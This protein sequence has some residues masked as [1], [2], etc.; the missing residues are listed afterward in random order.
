MSICR[1]EPKGRAL[2]ESLDTTGVACAVAA[3]PW[4]GRAPGPQ[5][6]ADQRQS[7]GLRMPPVSAAWIAARRLQ[8]ALLMLLALLLLTPSAPAS[9]A[10]PQ[11]QPLVQQLV[12]ACARFTARSGLQFAARESAEA[13]IEAVAARL[14]PRLLTEGGE[15]LAKRT[16]GLV[17]E[18]GP[19]L[20]RVLDD[21][22]LRLPVIE[23]LEKVP[24]AGRSAA[25]SALIREG[26]VLGRALTKVGSEALEAEMRHPGIGAG[27]VEVLGPEGAS[28]AR[29]LPSEDLAVLARYQSQIAGLPAAERQGLM[30]A[31][32]RN[33]RG[34]CDYLRAHP[35]F[36]LTS[37]TVALLLSNSDRTMDILENTAA[38]AGEVAADTVQQLTYWIAPVIA[39]GLG[40]WLLLRLRRAAARDEK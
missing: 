28:L 36:A 37:A 3:S 31:L 35:G 16:L 26:P 22:T 32:G 19:S 9:V 24:P 15:A 11:L 33:A 17:D 10:S 20:V 30:A 1:L 5:E 34:V 18:L 29:A 40:L 2:R 12:E 13:G 39:A 23:A 14:A 27:F 6:P 4:A 7:A 8:R 38:Q 21:Q 25:L